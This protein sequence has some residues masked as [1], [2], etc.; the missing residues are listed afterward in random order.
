MPW[1]IS[2]KGLPEGTRLG[3]PLTVIFA[4]R[5]DS[6]R[7]EDGSGQVLPVRSAALR[8]GGH[9]L[10]AGVGVLTGGQRPRPVR[11]RA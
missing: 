10:A 7:E 1:K 6:R 2:V 9:P 4:R 11:F 5:Q 8:Y 3:A